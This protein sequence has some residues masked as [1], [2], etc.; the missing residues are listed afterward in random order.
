[1]KNPENR[2]ITLFSLTAL[3]LIFSMGQSCS[4]NRLATNA[5]ANVLAG[6]GSTSTVFTGDDDPELV[7]AAL[8]FALKM[9]ELVLDKAP[10]HSALAVSTGSAFI[11]YAN[12][13]VESEAEEM[14]DVDARSSVRARAKRLY[15]RGVAYLDRALEQRSPGIRTAFREG[16][17][18]A[19]EAALR[20]FKASD[21]PLLY[22]MSAGILAAYALEPFDFA[23]GSQIPFCLDLLA[24][25]YVLDPDYNKGTLDSLYI[26]AYG[27]LPSDMGGDKDKAI[28]HYER[29]I[30]KS[31]GSSVS[32]HVA[33]ATAIALP[34][35]DY[36]E[37]KRL[38][39]LALSVDVHAD[40]T[41]RLANILAQ[42]KARRLLDSAPDLF[43]DLGEDE[44]F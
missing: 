32:S 44:P 36:P 11:M 20:R 13:F 9:Y 34:R 33:L 37:F 42:E 2:F 15:L 29:A 39:E 14:D 30:R 21:V 12:A 40:P 5:V 22:W 8:P 27:S 6:S 25:A 28:E 38:L 17:P 23:L 43:F 16:A 26:S 35:Q 3:T 4:I 41:N 31:N 19:R 1:M 7:G 18:G 10:R 24:R